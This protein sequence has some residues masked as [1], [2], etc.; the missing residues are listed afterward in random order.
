M[1]KLSLMLLVP[2]MLLLPACGLL[3]PKQTPV[4]VECPL[5]PPPPPEVVK[6]VSTRP[7]LVP[8]LNSIEDEFAASLLKARKQPLTPAR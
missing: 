1:R 2:A 5:V 6:S 8:Q 4:A 7:P 3:K